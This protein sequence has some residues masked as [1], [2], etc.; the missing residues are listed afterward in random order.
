MTEYEPGETALWK[1]L[2]EYLLVSLCLFGVVLFVLLRVLRAP[3]GFEALASLGA[4]ALVWGVTFWYAGYSERSES[5]KW[6]E[7]DD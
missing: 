4:T 1:V 2:V 6:W 7:K 3:F 5:W